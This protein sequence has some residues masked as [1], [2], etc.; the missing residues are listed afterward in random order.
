VQKLEPQQWREIF[1]L[2]DAAL[3]LP[4]SERHAWLETL[5]ATAESKATLRELLAKQTDAF[6]RDLP[7]FTQADAQSGRTGTALQPSDHV[8]PYRLL[9]TLGSGGMG[10]V[11]LSERADGAFKRTVALK[12]PHTSWSG[13]WAERLARERDILATLE[14]PNIARLYDAGVDE[15]GRPFMAMEYV[16]GVPIDR[17]CRDQQASLRECLQLVVQVAAALAHA[18]ARLVVHR[19][20]KPGNILVSTDGNVHLLDFGIA[21][22]LEAEPSE[23][24]LTQLTGRALTLDYASPEQIRGQPISTA[25]D[26]YSLAVVAYEL[27]TGARPYRLKQQ[28]APELERAISELDPLAASEAAQDPLRK[29]Q[30]RGDLDAILNKAMK[31]DPRERY[32]TADAFAQDINRFLS[33]VP[34]QARPDSTRYRLGKFIA[35]NKTAVAASAAVFIALITGAGVAMWQAHEA[36][37]QARRAEQQALRADQVKRFVLSIFENADFDSGASTATTAVDLLKRAEERID[38]EL[39][40]DPAMAVEL[41]TSVGYS[42]IG[43]GQPE[44]A[45]AVLVRAIALGERTIGPDHRLTV[46]ARVTRAEA[47]LQLDRFDEVGAVLPDAVADARRSGDPRILARS[48]WA[49]SALNLERGRDDEAETQAKEAVQIAETRFGPGDLQLKMELYSNLFIIERKFDRPDMLDS[50]RKAYDIAVQLDRATPSLATLATRREYATALADGGDFAAGVRELQAVI[51]E[52]TALTG[53]NNRTR[54]AA[55]DRLGA[56]QNAQG[57]AHGAVASLREQLEIQ[58]ALPTAA[59]DRGLAHLAL[60]NALMS[61]RQEQESEAELRQAVELLSSAVGA[62]HLFTVMARSAH[63]LAQARLGH[64]QQ[65]GVEFAQIHLASDSSTPDGA[66][67]NTRLGMLRNLQ[68]RFGEAES[69]LDPAI[70]TLRQ[71]SP[72][73]L[74]RLAFARAL[75]ALGEASLGVKHFDRALS[76]LTEARTLFHSLQPRG[77]TDA[78][79]NLVL[80]GRTLLAINQRDAAVS[81]LT[82]AVQFWDRFDSNNRYAQIARDWQTRASRGGASPAP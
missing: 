32:A 58:Q 67:L 55:L 74:N 17:Y 31:K 46:G 52:M 47:L 38:K 3:E 8:G 80:T 35:R 20:L 61:A 42:L 11:W 50:A 12:L 34:V 81:T 28:S 23:S 5:D 82:E 60:G 71:H 57:D 54:G 72:S 33:A 75:N 24:P 76:A 65:A 66:F 53:K 44:A 13:V 26:V 1:E 51:A 78:A 4:A 27:L 79:D 29:R 18:H 30:L 62:D 15:L 70:A 45:D 25:S 16:D 69:V 41:L 59:R 37:D 9:R 14:H 6:L 2:L 22:L 48:L 21:K 77:S 10:S 19:D 36:A 64:T 73:A 49:L 63:A 43:L 39:G 68:A 7:K 56:I 40:N